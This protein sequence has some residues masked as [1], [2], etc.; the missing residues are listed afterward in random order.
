LLAP[1]LPDDEW[2]GFF[3]RVPP[4]LAPIP[5]ADRM[6][7]DEDGRRGFRTPCLVVSPFASA[8]V[9]SLELDHTSVLR[10]IEWRWGL[11]PLTVRD[12]TAN[13]LA[14]ILDF[15]KPDL[16]AKQFRVPTGPFGAPCATA[17]RAAAGDKWEQLRQ[18]AADSGWP[19]SRRT[20]M[21]PMGA[22]A[23]RR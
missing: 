8:D 10:T 11:A 6:A 15:A 22:R 13:N 1:G 12:Q 21:W 16:K 19:V 23:G 18:M 2:G 3:D 4:A 7:G 20:T 17:L 14:E 5:E 9:S